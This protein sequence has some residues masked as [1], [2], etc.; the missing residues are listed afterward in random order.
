MKEG[1]KKFII[2]IRI[3][4]MLSI[5]M[6]VC[7]QMVYAETNLSVSLTVNR[8]E[9]ICEYQVK[10]IEQDSVESMTMEVSRLDASGTAVKALTKEI[11][12]SDD[13]FD[14]GT[15]IDTFSMDEIKDFQ[16]AEYS[17]SFT[18]GEQ[19]ITAD[20]TCD[21]AVHS[22]KWSLN[23]DS[24]TG[25]ATRTISFVSEDEVG[26]VYRPGTGSEVSLYVWKK[27]TSE[28]DAS[29]IGTAK[30][31]A[32]ETV[33]WNVDITELAESYGT[34]YAKLVLTD[35]N[36][37]SVEEKIGATHFIVQPS[38]TNLTTKVTDALEAKQSFRIVMKG[39]QNLYGVK[40]VTYNV[41]NSSNKKVYSCV[42]KD[43]NG[44]GRF[45][46]ADITMKSLNYKMDLYTIRAVVTDQ[47]GNSKLVS[48][49]TSIDRRKKAGTLKVTNNA[50]KIIKFSLKEA[51]LPGKIK[52]VKYLVFRNVDG[53]S[54][55]QTYKAAY[56]ASTDNFAATMKVTDFKYKA[57]GTY[58][59]YAYGYTQWG[60]KILLNKSTFKI[61]KATVTAQGSNSNNAKGTFDITVGSINSPSGVSEITIRVWK[62]G[63]T[64]DAH[65]YTAKKQSNGNYKICVDAKNH[66]YHFGKYQAKVFV[67]MGNGIKVKATTLSYTFKP[68][69]FVYFGETNVKNCRKIFIYN[70]SESGDITFQVYSKVK[71]TDDSATYKAVKK[72]NYAYTLIKIANIKNAGTIY[73]KA[74]VDG[75]LVRTFTFTL[76]SSE[77]LKNGWHYEK[78]NGKTYKFYYEDGEKVTD[79]TKVLGIRESSNS[80]F[81]NFYIEINRAACVVTVYAYD[82]E[83]KSYCIPVKTCTVSIGRDTWTT[84]GAGALNTN[85]SY[86]PLGTYSVSSNGYGVKFSMKP[87]YEPDGSTVYAR[88]ATHL[89]GN[90]YFHSIAVG[91]DSH[92][93]LSAST[94]NKLGSPASAG[95][96]R[97]T[98][99]DAKWIYDYVSKGTKV[100]IV[101]GSTKYP[102]PL[103]KN[104]TIKISSSIHY[105]PTDPAVPLSTKQRDYKAGRISGYMTSDGK[106]VG[107]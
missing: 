83:R 43:Q 72:G 6:Y 38:C 34:F 59:V 84:K 101:Q 13:K 55:S 35:A 73:V 104:A 39:L 3:V 18:I 86:T 19:N 32:D 46:Y 24:N 22:D 98:V 75:K 99:A 89:V 48:T 100:N 78:Y 68:S 52:S 65:T 71:G 95:C 64:T 79:L 97:M 69:N 81:N 87:M 28:A 4:M 45:Y 29:L 103:G 5:V 76:K 37:D 31:L 85:T 66:K 20:D 102:G 90:V 92:Y 70:P 23:V 58:N 61:S 47:N 17:V 57:T 62:S 105:D 91:S 7:P 9:G 12:L 67:T 40:K 30:K 54:K 36:D 11:Y 56:V 2:G 10:G 94:Y 44:D 16:Y 33:S 41:Y 63:E 25:A 96:I 51:Y 15:F 14:N 8:A 26:E 88:W 50:D 80:N 27:G 107:Y 1:F 82:S 77:L 106:R 60:S 42:A 21:F 53:S 93:A 74:K 49:T